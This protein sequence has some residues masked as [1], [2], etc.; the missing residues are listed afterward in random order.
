MRFCN[1]HE[2]ELLIFSAVFYLVWELHWL[3]LI[4]MVVSVPLPWVAV[5]IANG[6]G[7]PA[8]KR[9]PR[10][11][12]PAVIREQNRLWEQHQRQALQQT[13]QPLQLGAGSHSPPRPHPPESSDQI[14]DIPPEV[15]PDEN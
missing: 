9:A 2:C 5:V 3:A 7:E 15:S 1:G 14:I 13:G 11:Y 6:V 4:C 12:K 8:D 10:V